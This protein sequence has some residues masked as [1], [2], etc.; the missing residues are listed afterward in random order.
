MTMLATRRAL[1]PL[2]GA[3]VKMFYR[4]VDTV[5]FWV[6][7][8]LL[9]LGIFALVQELSFGFEGSRA[10]IDFFSFSAIGYGAF[11][12]AHFAQDGVVAAA[13]GYRASGVL[14]R[15]AVTPIA[16]ATFITAQVVARL[17][18]GV[19]ATVVILALGVALGADIQYTANLVWIVP[20]AAIAILTGVGFAF[21]IAGVMGTPEAANQLNVGIFT[22]IFLLNGAQ[23][24][25][26]GL[27]GGFADVAPYV[28]PFAAV[29]EAFRGVVAGAPITDFGSEIL[30]ALAWL[31]VAFALASRAYRF[32]E[33]EA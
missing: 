11:I 23:Y 13:S 29:I 15:I 16:P 19:V 28:V 22:P 2:F 25:L 6:V 27:A 8:P 5:L 12:A 30:A 4:S 14:K 7:S 33:R 9:F 1:W 26:D 3:S 32:V 31:G 21:A 17:F 10:T 24:P 18:T 20:L